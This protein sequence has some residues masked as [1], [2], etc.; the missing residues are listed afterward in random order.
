MQEQQK[1]ENLTYLV[2]WSVL[3]IAPVLS[4]YV[5]TVNDAAYTFRWE[6]VLMVWR[7]FAV[8]LVIFL[9]H[10][11]FL[12][13][14]LVYKQKRAIYFSAIAV[15]IAAF[16]AYQCTERPRGPH[17]HHDKMRHE[18]MVGHQRPPTEEDMTF[19]FDHEPPPD[20]PHHNRHRD[21]KKPPVI[22]G[23]HD[24]IALVVLILMLGMNIGIKLYFKSRRDTKIMAALEK[25]NLE[26][27][28]EYLRYQLNPHFLMNTLN[29]IHALVDIDPERSK[30]AIIQLSKIL[31]YVLYESN[32]ERVPMTKEI[33]F[34]ENY[35]LLMR[36]RYTDKLTF[37]AHI[38]DDGRDVMVAPMLFISFVEN[39]FK[40][41]VSY[42]KESF[43][44]INSER[45]K[46][47]Q[48][49]DRL[50]WTCRNSK[51]PKPASQEPRQGGVGMV[52]VRQRL[53][54]IYGENYS[55]TINDGA[56]T[57]EVILDIP[58]GAA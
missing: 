15:I 29:N 38:L 50:L 46:G 25:E 10:N 49:E 31:R 41:G 36:M 11:F 27:Q 28:L 22:M 30:A 53:D 33:E 57:Y 18:Q 47:K 52:N 40:H 2:L 48:Q 9:F 43:I 34:M 24:I 51:H 56:D 13:H 32:H 1:H 54:L 23:E 19:E 21:D 16:I 37:S 17:R 4:L 42:Q 6:E 44:E 7:L 55:L 3:F 12:A 20:R 14:L 5:R 26:Q 58:L 39:A 45:Y 8:Y 35:V